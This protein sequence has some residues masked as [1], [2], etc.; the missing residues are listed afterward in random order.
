MD[1]Q[2]A[3][4]LALD[5]VTNGAVYALLALALVLVFSVT[6]VILVP[7][8]ELVAFSGL[9]VAFLEY[10]VA[11]A[12]TWLLIG[13]GAAVFVLEGV[14]LLRRTPQGFSRT[15]AW[16]G[17]GLKF[18]A[19]P[20]L[21]HLVVRQV[22]T[23][24]LP[25]VL[26]M[27][28][29]ALVVIPMGPMIYRVA[30]QPIAEASVLVLLI[31]AVAVHF[32][33]SGL[34]LVMFGPEGWRTEPLWSAV[35]EVATLPLQGQSLAVIAISAS[36]IV[37]LYLYFGNTLSGKALRATAV[38]RLGARLVGIGTAQAGRL[39]FTL[40]TAIGVLCGILIAPMTTMTY[41]GGFLMALKGFVG[42]IIGGLVSYP[43]AAAGALLVG[44]LE[45]FSSFWASA[46]KEV[47]VFTLILPVLLWRSLSRAL[48]VT[49]EEE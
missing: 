42:A 1:W 38:N 48:A 30:F 23:M 10:G 4:F 31:V 40:A 34:G 39:A 44:L 45:A 27:A 19:F 13:L 11:P 47:I 5:G 29:A 20:M 17:N 16:V 43:L 26:Y 25:A 35:F 9:S 41:D 21:L 28:L 22:A 37:V 49:D 3:S 8:G 33:L 14:A 24:D 46:Y 2:I 12:T 32:A 36:L 7:L 18:L 6:R 15:G